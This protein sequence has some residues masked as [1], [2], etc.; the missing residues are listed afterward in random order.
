[1]NR[2]LTTLCA[3]LLLQTALIASAQSQPAQGAAFGTHEPRTCPSRKIAGVPNANQARALFV[4]DSEAYAGGYVYLV[5]DVA[6]QIGKSRPYNAWSDSGHSD[7]DV[8]LPVYPIQGHFTSW[9]CGQ[10]SAMLGQD[11]NRNCIRTDATEATGSCYK[12]TFDEWHCGMIGR[13]SA[14]MPGYQA[15][16]SGP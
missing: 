16:P 10:R 7:I 11:P 15:P 14:M 8:S 1:M 9:Q 4:C 2:L 13:R 5:S 6:V 12:S 3:A